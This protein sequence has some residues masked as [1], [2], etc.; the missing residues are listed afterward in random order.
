MF[1]IISTPLLNIDNE[2]TPTIV[3]MNKS[4]LSWGCFVA[5]NEIMLVGIY[6]A[7]VY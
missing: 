5:L 7:N 6:S 3:H 4:F 2:N 1:I